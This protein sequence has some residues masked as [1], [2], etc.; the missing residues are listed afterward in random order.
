MLF[1]K[2]GFTDEQFFPTLMLCFL[3]EEIIL[4]VRGEKINNIVNW[5][6]RRTIC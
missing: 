4:I 1:Q 3:K 6:L 2:P 5:E